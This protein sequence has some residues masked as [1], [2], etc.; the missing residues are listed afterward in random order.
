MTSL[1]FGSFIYKIRGMQESHS[2]RR[3]RETVSTP[4]TVCGVA[5]RVQRLR[6]K[7]G[8][9]RIRSRE[10]RETEARNVRE[11]GMRSVC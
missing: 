5:A 11:R 4:H 3:G 2:W 9:W 1:R 6:R 7:A 10:E 8:R